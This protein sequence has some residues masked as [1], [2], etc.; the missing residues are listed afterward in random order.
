[1]HRTLDGLGRAVELLEG[2]SPVRRPQ[3]SCRWCPLR[4]DC[5]DGSVYLAELA[6]RYD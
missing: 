5:E 6:D 3:A 1:M 4:D 2:R